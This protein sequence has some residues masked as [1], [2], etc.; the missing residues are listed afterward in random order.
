LIKL[1][2][3]LENEAD[4]HFQAYLPLIFRDFFSVPVEIFLNNLLLIVGDVLN[5][6]YYYQNR[7]TKQTNVF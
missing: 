7:K 5:H 3:E 4:K 1:F 2:T 6:V